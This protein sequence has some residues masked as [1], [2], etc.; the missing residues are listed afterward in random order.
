MKR[1]K[2]INRRRL[3]LLLFLVT[4]STGLFS[5]IV[6]FL[7]D[8]AFTSFLDR[9]EKLAVKSFQVLGLDGKTKDP[10]REKERRDLE[11]TTA[12]IE[13][14]KVGEEIV[15]FPEFSFYMLSYEK[16]IEENYGKKAWNIVS[17]GKKLREL[18]VED[19]VKEL[20]Q[21]KIILLEAKK[22]GV[23][24]NEK[25]EAEIEKTVD[26]QMKN[27][28]SVLVA[29]YYLDPELLSRI[30]S[31]NFL[32]DKFF[33][34]YLKSNRKE[35]KIEED[36]LFRTAYEEWEKNYEIEVFEENLVRLKG[37]GF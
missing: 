1:L 11:N 5:M 10:R 14:L 25:E 23:S 24:M 9:S 35:E 34:S 7:E 17:K 2:K 18:M 8:E 3:F 37:S 29:K 12:E 22:A 33:Y 27:I 36:R 6:F 4:L 21:L 16:E 28:D 32:A 30:Y 31:E 20:I 13:V 19:V 26:E 15:Y